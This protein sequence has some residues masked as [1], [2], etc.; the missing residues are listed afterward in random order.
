MLICP[1]CGAEFTPALK[2]PYQKYCSRECG[3]K[4]YRLEYHES[5]LKRNR[6]HREK[7]RERYN[8]AARE[9][10]WKHKW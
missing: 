3:L 1:V 5:I 7:N 8:A 2:T 4:G 10:Y 6:L 9:R